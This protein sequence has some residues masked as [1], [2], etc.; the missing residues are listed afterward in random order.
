M[1][2][3]S[4]S[5]S[6]NQC[7]CGVPFGEHAWPFWMCRPRLLARRTYASK[8]TTPHGLR[9]LVCLCVSARAVWWTC[10]AHSRLRTSIYRISR[11]HTDLPLLGLTRIA[12]NAVPS[13]LYLSCF[14]RATRQLR[15]KKNT[16]GSTHLQDALANTEKKKATWPRP[17][18]KSPVNRKFC[19]VNVD[20][21]T[22]TANG[23]H[24]C[25]KLRPKREI[26]DDLRADSCARQREQ[27]T[28]TTSSY[29]PFPPPTCPTYP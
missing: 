3:C 6:T 11:A 26:L 12:A 16:T 9:A 24:M 15:I 10:F 4:L 17:A 25:R 7:W 23:M 2:A 14:R 5:V 19:E 1:K 13:Y 27:Q 18:T 28:F 21:A 22:D 20:K 8:T 29:D